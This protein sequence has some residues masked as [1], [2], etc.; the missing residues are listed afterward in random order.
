MTSILAPSNPLVSELA[1]NNTALAAGRICGR[2]CVLSPWASSVGGRGVPPASG[3]RHRTPPWEIGAKTILWS[4]PQAPPR[5]AG[6][7]HK[8]IAAPPSAEIFLSF[9]PAKKATHCPSGEKKRA[10]APS[11]PANSVAFGWFRR[12]G[13]RRDLCTHTRLARP[14]EI[15][16]P[17]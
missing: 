3:I 17:V 6:A 2:R 4:T 9:P 12:R 15:H 8:V 5:A 13:N 7:S 16:T 10:V 11:V 1:V 14:R